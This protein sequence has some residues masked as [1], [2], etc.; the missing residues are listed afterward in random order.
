[1]TREVSIPITDG[2]YQ[3]VFPERCIYC[4]APSDRRL[5]KT[6]SAGSGRRTRFAT[7]DVPYCAK[8][9][10]LSRR[11]ARILNLGWVAILLFSCCVIFG[12]TT[13]INRNP[14]VWLWVVLALIAGVLAFAGAR[15]LRVLLGRSNQS[16]ADML[17]SSHL[18]L[19]AELAGDEIIL[20][21]ANDEMAEEF[22][23]LNGRPMGT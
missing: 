22:A 14:P 4:G 16:M 12:V 18:G 3:V 13:S 7:L 21:F 6:V 8:H 19:K 15:M 1:M 23:Q 2:E 11:N 10:Q 17:D 20:T 9:A 5:R